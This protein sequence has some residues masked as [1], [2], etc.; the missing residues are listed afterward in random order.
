M[1][2]L[3]ISLTTTPPRMGMITPTLQDLLAQHAFVQ[4]I[5]LNIPRSYR[6]FE[7]DL[8]QLPQFPPG[9]RVVLVG[10]DFGP[11]TKILPTVRDHAGQDIDILF[12]D[13][14]QRYEK[15]WAARF[16]ETRQQQPTAC[17][18]ESGYDL[19]YKHANRTLFPR[20]EQRKKDLRYRLFR[21]ATALQRRPPPYTKSGYVDILRGY[22]G[23]MVHAYDF[24][25]TVFDIPDILWT[26]DDVWL[27][28][29]LALNNV[30]VWL[31]ADVPPSVPAPKA[32]KIE[33]L[34]TFTYKGHDRRLADASCVA[35]FQENYNIW[36]PA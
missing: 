24:L 33:A 22:R 32:D 31:L 23:A 5:R 4:E 29:Q 1:R 9:I 34:R 6:R 8:N 7:F 20:A 15:D 26:V 16:V 36:Q 19:P 35:F 17:L 28:G 27:S 2:D 10:E 3:I 21:A 11:A 30:P 18:V 12:C 14:D 25:D 13:D